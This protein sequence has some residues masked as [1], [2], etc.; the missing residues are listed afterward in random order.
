MLS[1][2][3][4]ASYAHAESPIRSGDRIAIVG[5]TF[6]DQ[7]RIHGYLET[8]LRQRSD[9]SVRNLGWAG[10]ML[11]ARDRPIGFPTEESTLTEHK[12]DVIIACF[13][14]GESFE[15]EAGLKGF[16]SDL[17]AFIAT[18]SGKKYNGKS[19]VRLILVSPIANENLGNLTPVRVKRNR[20]LEAYTGAMQEVAT[21]AKLP[22]VNLF[23][24]SRYLM[25]ERAGPNLTTNG[26]TLNRFGYWAISRVFLEQLTGEIR[27]PWMLNID[28][29]A[30]SGTAK[31]VELSKITDVNNM[32]SFSVVEQTAP[33][34]RPPSDS[35][36]PPQLESQRDTLMVASLAPGEYTL[37]VDGV[38]VVT[39]NHNLWA[40]GVAVDASPS[41]REAEAQRA[42]INDKNLQFTYSWKALNQVHIVGERKSSPS[43]RSLPS[44]VVEFNK[45]AKQREAELAQYDDGLP[46]KRR[47]QLVPAK[48]ILP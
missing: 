26:I 20:E 11:T 28:A 13:G 16:K 5:N 2:C 9:H 8:L 12:T 3:L 33:S 1:L 15:G 44:E 23:D 36:L 30:A 14:M 38:E 29:K 45:L 43:G 7:L 47:W 22:F 21:S 27:Q 6:A 39:A 46:R 40:K 18:H 32:V 41:H 37:T 31:G 34:L 19:E 17:E 10:D 4:A 35:E 48:E 42:A 25:D 24:A